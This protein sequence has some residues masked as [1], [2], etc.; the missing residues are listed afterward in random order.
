M[1]PK[2][3]T[4]KKS[5]GLINAPTGKAKNRREAASAKESEEENEQAEL[6]EQIK[7]VEQYLR[8]RNIKFQSIQNL[9]PYEQEDPR[10]DQM[11]THADVKL[12]LEERIQML[13]HKFEEWQTLNEI[14]EGASTRAT[15][16]QNAS[17]LNEIL[18]NN[19][20]STTGVVNAQRATIYTTLDESNSSTDRSDEQGVLTNQTS[21]I[22]IVNKILSN[23]QIIV[24]TEPCDKQGKLIPESQLEFDREIIV[25]NA[26]IERAIHC[27]TSVESRG[28][29][30]NTLISP[31]GQEQ[32]LNIINSKIDDYVNEHQRLEEVPTRT[33]YE[34]LKAY[35]NARANK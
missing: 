16:S 2:G 35:I 14:P 19:R 20:T 9:H 27:T 33:I 21:E 26:L 5:S 31:N 28:V 4:N 6:E 25:V 13:K 12:W 1:G 3:N 7:L 22:D 34:H 24:R 11:A 32:I 15:S 23:N 10:R 17:K 30:L 8:E 29:L 18:Y